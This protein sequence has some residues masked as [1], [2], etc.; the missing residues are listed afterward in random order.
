MEDSFESR[1]NGEFK[2]AE[3]KAKGG[4]GW[5]VT[6]IILMILLIGAGVFAGIMT[7]SNNTN[8]D[9]MLSYEKQVA[10]KDTKISELET[11]ITAKDSEIA[12]LKNSTVTPGTSTAKK[13]S[14]FKIDLAGL[15]KLI[16]K[17]N[18][19]YGK[20]TTKGLDLVKA[21]FTSDDKYLILATEIWEGNTS[22]AGTYYKEVGANTSW[23]VLFEGHQFPCSSASAE[24]KSFIEK[25]K[26]F[27]NGL[28]SH[29]VQ[30]F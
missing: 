29:W 22:Y 11:T 8:G 26:A 13:Y 28:E 10:E 20:V 17:N 18:P 23:K 12:V 9:K 7:F 16:N 1:L 21:E 15:M 25:Y 27:D 24:Q 19:E 30:C 6:S 2:P 4:K 14:D 5:M 3:N